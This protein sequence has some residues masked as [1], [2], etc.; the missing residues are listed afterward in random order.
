MNKG[1]KILLSLPKDFLN[2]LDQTLKM[3]DGKS[4]SHGSKYPN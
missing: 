3:S 4:P 2:E 1:I